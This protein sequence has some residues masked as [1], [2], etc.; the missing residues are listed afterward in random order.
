MPGKYSCMLR[1]TSMASAV[2][3]PFEEVVAGSALGLPVASLPVETMMET[4]PSGLT[5]FGEF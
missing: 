1:L 2:F 3:G 5:V 4:V